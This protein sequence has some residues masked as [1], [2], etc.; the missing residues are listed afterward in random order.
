MESGMGAPLKY[1]HS[2]DN[3]AG[4]FS[5]LADVRKCVEKQND[6]EATDAGGC[7][8]SVVRESGHI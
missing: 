3:Y 8:Q 2:E 4:V 1:C 7:F 5:V 6:T